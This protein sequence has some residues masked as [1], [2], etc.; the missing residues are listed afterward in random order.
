MQY[1]KLSGLLAER[2]AVAK[3]ADIQLT[4]VTKFVSSGKRIIRGLASTISVDRQNDVVV[5][6]AGSWKLPV[7]L[8]WQHSHKDPVGWVRSI[9]VRSD[10][11][12]I[13]AEF[14]EGIGRADEIWQMVNARLIDNFSIGFRALK[15]EPLPGGGLRF[16]KWEL[17]E[18]SVVVVPANPDAKISRGSVRLTQADPTLPKEC[19]RLVS[20]PPLPPGSVRLTSGSPPLPQG[21]VRISQLRKGGVRLTNTSPSRGRRPNGIPGNPGAVR[22]NPRGGK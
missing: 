15:S 5:P 7:P 4:N 18:I 3:R 9:E 21:A 20:V 11:L 19:V 1:P 14:A 22:I 10:G 16:T 13:E 2:R 8:L 12:W 6:T 17:L